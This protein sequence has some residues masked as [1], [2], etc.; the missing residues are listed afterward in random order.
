MLTQEQ[1]TNLKP[2]DPILIHGTYT[3]TH[4]D[5]DI[6]YEAP[7]TGPDDKISFSY[8]S[9]TPSCV[10]LPENGIKNTE[11][12]P[13]YD[14]CRKFRKGDKVR[15]VSCRGRLP[16]PFALNAFSMA[17]ILTVEEDENKEYDVLVNNDSFRQM[18]QACY[19]ELVTPVEELEPYSVGESTDYFSVDDR[20]GEEL[21][22]YWKDKHPHAKE[23]AEA[24]CARLNAEYRK[25]QQK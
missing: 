2:G 9:T 15:L 17:E 4:S 7:Y 11:A 5:G 16:I 18:F 25:E 14:P 10:S 23:A 20:E 3:K 8:R 13:K 19:L 24:E 21:S 12:A 6:E 22:I 1:I